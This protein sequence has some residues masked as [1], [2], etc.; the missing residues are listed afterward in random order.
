ML[1]ATGVPI[2]PNEKIRTPIGPL[3]HTT[4]S[5]SV[6]YLPH[7]GAHVTGDVDPYEDT[8]DGG[9][10]P[11]SHPTR[12]GGRST[13]EVGQSFLSQVERPPWM[14]MLLDEF[15]MRMDKRFEKIERRSVN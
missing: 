5:R 12:R 13:Y 9:P 10:P 11:R 3:S 2:L 4:F 6:T 8:M 7:A 15:T 1:V 14:D